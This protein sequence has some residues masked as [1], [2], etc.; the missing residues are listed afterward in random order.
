MISSSEEF[1]RT[2]TPK[3]R[4]LSIGK[5]DLVYRYGIIGAIVGAVLTALGITLH[6]AAGSY[7]PALILIVAGICLVLFG[8]LLLPSA[9]WSQHHR[10][11]AERSIRLRTN[12][13]TKQLRKHPVLWISYAVIAGGVFIPLRLAANHHREHQ[14]PIPVP[15]LITIGVC[16][17]V[18]L[19]AL[20]TYLVIRARRNADPTHA[21][22]NPPQNQLA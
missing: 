16:G 21:N 17:A 2:T 12:M 18:L 1:R 11:E 19:G 15:W 22:P 4:L 9:I 3:S 10:P 14:S 6:L 5:P 20:Q 8:L 13:R 7:T